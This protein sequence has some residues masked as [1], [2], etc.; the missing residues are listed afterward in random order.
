M[1]LDGSLRDARAVKAG[2][3][4]PPPRRSADGIMGPIA[5]WESGL[6]G[7]GF[8]G[9]LPHTHPCDHSLV[10]ETSMGAAGSRTWRRASPPP[11]YP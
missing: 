5:T 3:T 7:P 11:I 2:G 4:P 8:E 10:E 1:G 9:G 6:R